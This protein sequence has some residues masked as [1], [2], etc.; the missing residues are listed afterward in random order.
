[1]FNVSPRTIVPGFNVREPGFRVGS[2]PGFRVDPMGEPWGISSD[3]RG[4]RPR[5]VGSLPKYL[6]VGLVAPDAGGQD[7]QQPLWPVTAFA[8]ANKHQQCVDRCYHLLMRPK[9]N[10]WDDTNQWD[11]LKC[12]TQ[13]MSE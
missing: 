11:Y 3:D 5:R 12:Y 7:G 10:P 2:V 1:M 13:C 8:G 6:G 4:M 9:P